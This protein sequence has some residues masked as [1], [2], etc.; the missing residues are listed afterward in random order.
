M[1]CIE[2][3]STVLNTATHYN[4]LQPMQP[5]ASTHWAHCNNPLQPTATK[6]A[7]AE[8]T[9]IEICNFSAAYCKTLQQLIGY[10]ATH[11]NKTRRSRSDVHRKFPPH[12]T[13]HLPSSNERETHTH[14]D[15]HRDTHIPPH[16]SASSLCWR[17][18]VC[19]CRAR[20]GERGGA[21]REGGEMG[22]KERGGGKAIF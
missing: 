19:G 4:T 12:P 9:C 6:H 13:G 20:G 5:T 18:W 16:L 7:G 14:T 3:W 2:I 17:G 11:C 22:W 8:V 10:T 21:K 1:T 15:T